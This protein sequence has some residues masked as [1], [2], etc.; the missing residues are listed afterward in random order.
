MQEDLL[1]LA[2]LQELHP[3]GKESGLMLSQEL[4]RISL[5]QCEKRMTTLLRHDPSREEDGAIEL[6]RLKDDLRNE[7]ENS[8]H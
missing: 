7:F 5:S 6:W 8:Q 2:H 3:S 4:I 1:L